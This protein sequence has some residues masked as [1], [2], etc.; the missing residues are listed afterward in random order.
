MP[1]PTT[2]TLRRNVSMNIYSRYQPP[3]GF[4][5]YAYLRDDLSPYYIGKGKGR[6]AWVH[7]TN[8][9]INPPADSTGVV[10]IEANLTEL[11][12]WAIERRLIRWYGR[13]DLG[14]GILRNK[15][16]GGEGCSGIKMTTE[17]RRK[18]GIKSLGR[19]GPLKGK[20]RPAYI[21]QNISK[22]LKGKPKSEE[23]RK[24]NSLAHIG[25]KI[26][27]EH[28]EKAAK[29]RTG[30]KRS[31]EFK[32]NQRKLAKE[33]GWKPPSIDPAKEN[34]SEL[35]K[36]VS[37]GVTKMWAERRKNGTASGNFIWITNGVDNNKIRTNQEIPQGWKRGR[38]MKRNAK[39]GSFI[40]QGNDNE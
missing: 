6:R 24:N 37:V 25:K 34:Y 2:L 30:L 8:D 36:K 5:V 31:E 18:I 16:D 13:K 11:G 20:R 4:Y 23:H 33:K 19:P 10:I 22:K 9:V 3:S 40:K 35:C 32:N 27:R 17:W 15:T 38:N 39:T 7:T 12:A 1:S 14:T 28:V 29:A 21:G 26:L